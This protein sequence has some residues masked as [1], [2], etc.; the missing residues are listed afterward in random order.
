MPMVGGSEARREGPWPAC[1]TQKMTG[2][3]C[4]RYIETYADDVRGNVK[5]VQPDMMVTMDFRTDR[6]W[7]YV[8]A[9]GYVSM[10]PKRG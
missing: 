5:L 7:V 2:S 3:E 8:D 9:D 1:L 4:V 10:V 6:V